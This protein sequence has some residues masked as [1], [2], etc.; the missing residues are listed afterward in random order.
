M[1]SAGL[2]PGVPV[3]LRE[4]EPSSEMFKQGASLRVTGILQAYDVDSATAIIQDGSVSLKVD[5]QNLRDISFRT[6]SAYQFIG[7][8]LIHA[9]NEQGYTNSPQ[10]ILQARIGRNVD[11]L[12]LNLYQQSLLIR[13]Q[14]EAKLRNSRRA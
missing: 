11:G 5:T 12:D 13:R 8:L 10:A 3:I 4:L 2:K 7:E 9:E 14:H 6:N 1:A